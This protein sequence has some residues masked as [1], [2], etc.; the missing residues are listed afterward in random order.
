MRSHSPYL[1]SLINRAHHH[2]FGR[3]A[4][5]HVARAEAAATSLQAL[6]EQSRTQATRTAHFPATAASGA[7]PASLSVEAQGLGAS[8]LAAISSPG[9]PVVPETL[10]P[11]AGR[12]VPQPLVSMHVRM[13]DKMREM[14]IA[15]F[16][17]YLSMLVRVRAHDPAAHTVWLS[18]EMQ[19][20]SDAHSVRMFSAVDCIFLLRRRASGGGCELNEP[21]ID[22]L[23]LLAGV[24]VHHQGT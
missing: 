13:G 14:R 11:R 3:Q 4:A 8:A 15:G 19:P 24:L 12:W 10:H 20:V 9:F 5:A 23:Q 18:T 6:I 2:S 21:L 22:F 7:T 16:S 17:E 1:C